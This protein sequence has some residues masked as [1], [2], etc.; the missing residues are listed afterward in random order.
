MIGGVEMSGGLYF[1]NNGSTYERKDLQT[2]FIS[3]SIVND[4]KIMLWNY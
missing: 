2:C 4:S 3:I 1:F